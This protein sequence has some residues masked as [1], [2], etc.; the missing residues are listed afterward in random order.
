MSLVP[1]TVST[2]PNP[3]DGKKSWHIG[4]MMTVLHVAAEDAGH[5][6]GSE[7]TLSKGG[8]L[9]SWTAHVASHTP[10]PPDELLEKKYQ[11]KQL[12]LLLSSGITHADMEL[13]GSSE[14]RVT[15]KNL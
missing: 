1:H 9:P 2:A 3:Q 4:D 14:D 12:A 6:M 5:L 8:Q 11:T 15:G 7:V 10:A 13:L